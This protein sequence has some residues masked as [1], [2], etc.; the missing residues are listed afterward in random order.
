MK[1]ITVA[2]SRS[3]PVPS[4]S[5]TSTSC[6]TG[7]LS[8]ILTI[9]V[10]ACTTPAPTSSTAADDDA[11]H[12]TPDT[13]R[14]D[15]EP[16]APVDVAPDTA[17]DGPDVQGDD[18]QADVP[19]P[20]CTAHATRCADEVTLS[21]CAEDGA[22][23]ERQPCERGACRG[24]DRESACVPW[25][26]EP[27]EAVGCVDDTTGEVCS[28]D[29]LELHTVACPEE[30]LC[31]EG[32]CDESGVTCRTD[33]G[34]DGDRRCVDQRCV[35]F[36]ADE[37]NP[38][39]RIEPTP[40]ELPLEVQCAWDRGN[41]DMEPVVIDL[42]LDGHPEIVFTTVTNLDGRYGQLV[43]IDGRTCE[44]VARTDPALHV[45]EYAGL[46]AGDI[47]GDGMPEIVARGAAGET[48]AFDGDL[49]LLWTTEQVP[50]RVGRTGQA[51]ALVNLNHDGAPEIIL[52]GRVIFG[53]SGYSTQTGTSAANSPR[54]TGTPC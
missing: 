28:L 23:W 39:C 44:E 32:R 5:T 15:A 18:V 25:V 16:D 40:S 47:N 20:V 17:P 6:L 46:G 38:Q 11:G 1:I 48:W 9:L 22:R 21:V 7:S 19:A 53:D 8:A 29:G 54:V 51:P 4:R 30:V 31:V 35:A 43:A 41:V 45:A 34:C 42:H 24:A 36:G 33:A 10:V 52:S 26:C 12:D 49:Q 50:G 14:A 3:I 2:L 37:S 27:G 13:D